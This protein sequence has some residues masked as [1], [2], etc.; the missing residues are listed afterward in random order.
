[1]ER[2]THELDQVHNSIDEYM[3]GRIVEKKVSLRQCQVYGAMCPSEY[4]RVAGTGLL[5]LALLGFGFLLG[6]TVEQ[7]LLGEI[8]WLD[9]SE[10]IFY[11]VLGVAL[12][13][14]SFMAAERERPIVLFSGWFLFFL[15]IWGFFV[16]E[17]VYGMH[18]ETTQSLLY[19][20]LW[21]WSLFA[22]FC[23][24]VREGAGPPV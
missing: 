24:D 18:I 14:A 4:A 16:S 9:I 2:S 8:W 19:L 21:A 5:V 11:A 22:G 3:G 12:L 10:V 1:M 17:T 15:S 7:S 6:P 13:N 23:K 20:V